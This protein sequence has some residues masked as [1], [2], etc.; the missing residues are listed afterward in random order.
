MDGGDTLA[1]LASTSVMQ[2]KSA[3]NV[4]LEKA[5]IVIVAPHTCERSVG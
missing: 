2:Q 4:A 3:R 1:Q 5:C